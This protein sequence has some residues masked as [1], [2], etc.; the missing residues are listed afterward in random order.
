MAT[1]M[2]DTTG[3]GEPKEIATTLLQLGATFLPIRTFLIGHSCST[4]FDTP[5]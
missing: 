5:G 1:P 2:I 3:T 4:K